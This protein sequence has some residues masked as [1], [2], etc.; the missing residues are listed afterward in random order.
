MR[1]NPVRNTVNAALWLVSETLRVLM[2]TWG[3][4]GGIFFASFAN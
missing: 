1:S 4:Y 3:K 2:N